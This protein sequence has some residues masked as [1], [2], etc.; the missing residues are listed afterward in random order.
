MGPLNFNT[1]IWIRFIVQV[2][3]PII[4]RIFYFLAQKVHV[5]LSCE[6]VGKSFPVYTVEPDIPCLD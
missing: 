6:P 1:L 2:G 4:N 5:F 3:C